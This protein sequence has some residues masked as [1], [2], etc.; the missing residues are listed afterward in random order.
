[1][2]EQHDSELALAVDEVGERIRTL[3]FAAPGAY[4]AGDQATADLPMRRLERHEKSA[5]ML[6]SLLA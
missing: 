4:Q 3:G 6:R 5:W 2:F 1:M